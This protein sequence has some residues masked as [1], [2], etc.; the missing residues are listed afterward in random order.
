M[1]LVGLLLAA[2]IIALLAVRILHSSSSPAGT[3]SG[4]AAAQSRSLLP[5][6]GVDL[7]G[8]NNVMVRVGARQSVTVHAD[9]NLLGR[10][11]TRVQA[12]S[13][14]IGT[15]PG[16]L[17]AK[18]PMYVA[19]GVPS[20]DRLALPGAGNISVTGIDSRILTLV[21][22]GSGTVSTTGTTTRLDVTISGTGTAL[23]SGL[24][25]RDAKA[26]LS[27]DGSIV[28]T[29]THSVDASVS[30][31]GTIVYGG[32]PALVTKAVTGSGTIAGG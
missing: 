22:P 32:N 15:T 29:A 31:S 2:I 21:L 10:V 5:F 24:I 17:N 19:V 9:R 4:V 11:T 7:A 13:L 12:G 8:A 25:A 1:A 20:I 30:G 3:G 16:P 14:V 6:T 23:L 18:R 26:V 28:L 27:G